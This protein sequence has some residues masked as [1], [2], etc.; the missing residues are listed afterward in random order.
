M[1]RIASL[2]SQ[3]KHLK[4]L[5]RAMAD[6][7][8]LSLDVME[9][10]LKVSNNEDLF[11]VIVL[12]TE[13]D[14][15][16]KVIDKSI[17]QIFATN[18][19]LAYELRMTYAIAKIAHH[20]E[21]IG[22]AVEGLARQLANRTSLAYNDIIASMLKEARVLFLRSYKAMFEGDLQQIQ[23]I[24]EHDDVVD[25]LQRE[26]YQTARYRLYSTAEK[27]EID[28]SLK[29]INISIK[30]EKIADLSCNWAEQIDFME[31]GSQRQMLGKKNHKVVFA[32][33]QGGLLASLASCI[34]GEMLGESYDIASTTLSFENINVVTD[35]SP[36]LLK[37]NVSPIMYPIAQF[38]AMSWGRCLVLIVLGKARLSEVQNEAVPYKTMKIYWD[39]V[40]SQ[41]HQLNETLVLLCKHK[42][43]ELSR[44]LMR[45]QM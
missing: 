31:H 41:E 33:S 7:V 45:T 2:E 23:D 42:C 21:R 5:L 40:F 25:L 12:D 18:Q 29:I 35:H 32:D 22:D 44:V 28:D 8:L 6:R 34:L 15:M 4:T 16:E 14:N 1:A 20:I 13:V 39:D 26:L 27:S 43:D 3:I 24:H 10:H 17:L 19:P 9:S 30:L 36:L 11:R 38:A 37:Q